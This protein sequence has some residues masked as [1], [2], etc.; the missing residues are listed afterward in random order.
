[1]KL[2]GSTGPAFPSLSSP[3]TS[4]REHNVT[5]LLRQHTT[6]QASRSVYWYPIFCKGLCINYP[7]G[8]FGPLYPTSWELHHLFLGRLVSP[9]IGLGRVLKGLPPWAAHPYPLE[10]ERER[11]GGRQRVK[12]PE[13]GGGVGS[14]YLL[15]S[16]SLEQPPFVTALSSE[17]LP[18]GSTFNLSTW[19]SPFHYFR[20][21][22]CLM[23]NWNCLRFT[24][25]IL[26]YGLNK[27][28]WPWQCR[29]DWCYRLKVL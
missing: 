26:N 20:S 25:K 16:Q 22:S 2:L 28:P 24:N 21:P 7:G 5:N 6:D 4:F 27:R 29:G 12:I 3:Y 17:S 1:M 14:M 18:L 11:E 19:A 15:S 8:L 23:T 9:I 13:G 10:R